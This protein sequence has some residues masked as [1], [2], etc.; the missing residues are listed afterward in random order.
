[1]ES[2]NLRKFVEQIKDKLPHEM[3]RDG[4]LA[5]NDA[6]Q[7]A[8][9][10][11][12]KDRYRAEIARDTD[13]QLGGIGFFLHYAAKADGLTATEFHELKPIAGSLVSRNIWKAEALQRFWL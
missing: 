2:F 3:L 7:Q 11:R 10:F 12:K 5:S 6:C 4:T 1:M 13:R 8:K 9:R